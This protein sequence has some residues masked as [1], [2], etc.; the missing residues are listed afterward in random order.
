MEKEGYRVRPITD[1]S[2]VTLAA[3]D[4]LYLSDVHHPGN[5]PD[6]WKESIRAYVD[7]GGSV[8]QTWHHHILGEVGVGV[9]RVYGKRQMRVVPGHPA[10][11]GITDFESRFKDHIV[12]SVGKGA[13]PLLKNDAGDVVAVAGTL[14]KGKVISTGLALAIPDGNYTAAPRGPETALLAGFVRWLTPET[15]AAEMYSFWDALD[16]GAGPMSDAPSG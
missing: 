8:L 1:L 9:R 12:E 15:P 11:E 13:V 5:V 3:H 2:A 10:V 6:G 7:A 16:G 4:I 14:G